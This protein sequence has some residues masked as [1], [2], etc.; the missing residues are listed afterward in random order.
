[1]AD[2]GATSGKIDVESGEYCPAIAQMLNEFNADDV[3][4]AILYFPSIFSMLTRC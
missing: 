1:M 4:V 3:Q 2:N